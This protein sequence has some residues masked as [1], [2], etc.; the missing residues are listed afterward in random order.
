MEDRPDYIRRMDAE[1]ADL[2]EKLDKLE[3][4]LE[5]ET[6]QVTTLDRDELVTLGA[7]YCAMC[8]YEGVLATRIQQWE[9]GNGA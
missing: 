3:T 1:I 5:Q 8:M 9:D 7:Q 2:R 4:L 6:G